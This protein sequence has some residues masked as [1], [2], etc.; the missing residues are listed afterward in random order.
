MSRIFMDYVANCRWVDILTFVF[1][2]KFYFMT[3]LIQCASIYLPIFMFS[4][5][6][7]YR[8]RQ[9][10]THSKYCQTAAS[11]S[12]RHWI[13][14]LCVVFWAL[15]NCLQLYCCR[16]IAEPVYNK[17][18]C[19]GQENHPRAILKREQ[20]IFRRFQTVYVFIINT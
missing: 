7:V 1:R 5:H 18:L 3:G 8:Y 9:I 6:F 11:I 17:W 2:A 14:S 10:N 12:G 19:A 16:F 4:I 13:C 20:S 15:M